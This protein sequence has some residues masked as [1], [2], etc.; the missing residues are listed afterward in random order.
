MLT[1]PQKQLV[2]DNEKLIYYGIKKY[3]YG[4]I[5]KFYGAA[6]VGLC[7]AAETY[8]AGKGTKFSTYALRCICTEIHM[9]YRKIKSQKRFNCLSLEQNYKYNK[10]DG[11][12]HSI[13]PK[14]DDLIEPFEDSCAAHEIYSKTELADKQKKAFNLWLAGHKQREIAQLMGLTQSEVSRLIRHATEKMRKVCEAE[15]T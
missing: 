11:S 4:D 2:E 8:Q 7:R 13:D 12:T 10:S 14:A 1:E 15:D 5:E 3:A 6:A 9:E